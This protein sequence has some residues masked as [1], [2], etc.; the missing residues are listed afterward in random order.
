MN[1]TE[2]EK[3]KA[4]INQFDEACIE[5]NNSAVLDELVSDEVINHA[6]RPGTP[7]GKESFLHFLSALHSGLS[8][9]KV[10]ALHQVAEH[11]LVVTQKIISG[12][13]TGNLF[14]VQ[15]NGAYISFEAIEIIR[16]ENGKY[17]E[18]WVQSNMAQ[19]L[20]MSSDH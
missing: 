7:N 3:N 20:G 2:L 4:V 8:E 17:M 10:K 5:Q 16:L 6:S 9:I 13:H 14:G 11:D 19:V 1:N 18:H 15:G 12:K